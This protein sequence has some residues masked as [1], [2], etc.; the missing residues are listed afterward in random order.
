MAQWKTPSL[1]VGPRLGLAALLFLVPIVYLVWLVTS[2]QKVAIS[3]AAKE[4]DGARYL[5]GLAAVQ[6]AADTAL[7]NGTAPPAAAFSTLGGS[8]AAEAGRLAVEDAVA[9][10]AAAMAGADL[11]AARAKLRDLIGVIG[12]HSNLILDNVLDSYYLTDVVLN[13]LPELLDRVTDLAGGAPKPG[14]DA[15]TQAHFLEGV[16]ALGG[17]LDGMSASMASAVAA[18]ADGTLK[19]SLAD[20]GTALHDH[21]SAFAAALQAPGGTVPDARPLLG[22]A[23]AFADAATA[24]LERM[25]T[26][27]VA[28]FQAARLTSLLISFGLFAAAV[29]AVLLVVRRSVIRPLTAMTQATATLARGDLDSPLPAPRG[30]DELSDLARALAVF[31]EALVQ[32]RNLQDAEAREAAIRKERQESLEALAQDFNRAMSGQLKLVADEALSLRVTADELAQ[33]AERTNARSGEVESSAAVASQNA[34]TVA[35]ATEQLAA[36]SRE[37][38][39]QIEHAARATMGVVEQAD[40][41]RQLVDELTSVMTGTTQVVD[42]IGGIARQTNLLA[43]NATI[44]A[45]RAGESGKGFAVVAQEV[46]TLATQTANATSDIAGRIDAVRKSAGDAAQIIRRMADLV[47]NVEASSNAIAAAVTEQNAATDEISRSVNES[48]RC[49]NEVSDG[50]STVRSDAAATGA[51]AATLLGSATDLSR[52]AQQ[53]REEVVHFLN[54]MAQS[55]DRR[56][57]RRHDID[58]P[59]MLTPHGRAGQRGRA[60]NV[61]ASGIAVESTIQTQIGEEIAVEGIAHGSLHARVV[62]LREGLVHL[63]FRHDTETRAVMSEFMQSRFAEAA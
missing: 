34:A 7:L 57:N 20:R 62:N 58:V 31:R 30:R 16:G 45:A 40:L 23:A 21:T 3:F 15:A 24:E 51:S 50:M 27:R 12:D 19:A 11:P 17:V 52:Q 4:V 5:R 53:L 55:T 60:V 33:R 13:R 28:G 37:I 48:S 54:A 14:S 6:A 36:S 2:E 59:V 44:E 42:F 49:T 29:A 1:R 10:A 25:L 38:S 41:A 9:A 39:G 61:S 56:R 47:R 35:A 8:L 26:Q 32:N 18:N 46:K 63:Q 22:E 43:L